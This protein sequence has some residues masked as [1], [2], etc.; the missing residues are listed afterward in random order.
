MKYRNAV[1]SFV[2][3]LALSGTARAF[4][5]ESDAGFA[6]RLGSISASVAKSVAMQRTLAV[7]PAPVA[8]VATGR[9]RPDSSFTP[10]HLCSPTDPNFK[11]YRYAEHIPY[12]QR[13]VT[14]AMKQEV[15][16][17]Y[18]IAEADWHNYEFDHLI[19]L[20]IGGDSSVD[21]LWPEPSADNQGPSG[22]DQLELQ[23]YIQMRDGKISQADAVKQIYAWFDAFMA[24][25]AK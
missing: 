1:S 5:P 17:H 19:P 9:A 6:A 4:A 22:K 18:G 2:A 7:V 14:R 21:N 12:C 11:E 20:A 25:R 23:L 8:P 24:K 15:G 16:A 13:S 10:G 3:L